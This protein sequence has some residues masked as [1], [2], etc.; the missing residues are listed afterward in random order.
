MHVSTFNRPY[1]TTPALHISLLFVCLLAGQSVSAATFYVDGTLGNNSNTGADWGHSFA[2]IVRAEQAAADGD[3]VYVKS[4]TYIEPQTP[5]GATGNMTFSK[6]ISWIADDGN[7]ALGSVIMR[8]MSGSTVMQFAGTKA[9]SWR[10]FTFDG[11][12]T[13][14][15]LALGSTAP[16]SNKTWTDVTFKDA[17]TYQLRFYQ[18]AGTNNVCTRCT[19]TGSGAY[20]VYSDNSPIVLNTPTFSLSNTSSSAVYTPNSPTTS[21]TITGGNITASGSMRLI[22][23]QSPSVTISNFNIVS[24]STNVPIYNA[25]SSAITLTNITGSVA[26]SL[27]YTSGG[28]SSVALSG[29]VLTIGNTLITAASTNTNAW[30]IENNTIT[31][32]GATPGYILSRGFSSLTTTEPIIIR[33]NTFSIDSNLTYG[34]SLVKIDA[35]VTISDNIF[36]LNAGAVNSGDIIALSDVTNPTIVRNTITNLYALNS[37]PIRISAVGSSFTGIADIE[38]NTITSNNTIGY[39][40]GLGSEDAGTGNVNADHYN[41]STI[42]S[43]I[44]HGPVYNGQAT[45]GTTHALFVG[46][47][48]FVD[49]KYNKVSGSGYA[50]VIKG[51]PSDWQYTSGVYQNTFVGNTFYA[52]P[53]FKGA[54]NVNCFN[55]TIIESTTQP[56][57]QGMIVPIY[58]NTSYGGA[59]DSSGIHFF[60]NLIIAGSANKLI[61]VDAF[62]TANSVFRNNVYWNADS[63]T[64]SQIFN[65]GGV[66]ISSFANWVTASSDTDSH[67]TDPQLTSTSNLTPQMMSPAVDAGTVIPSGFTI[68]SDIDNNPFYGAPDIGAYEFQPT[69]IVGTHPFES[70]RDI[71]IYDNAHYRYLE[72]NTNASTTL[73]TVTPSSG[74]H[75][76]TSNTSHET[77]ADIKISQWTP[78][79]EGVKAW[80]IQTSSSLVFLLEG[81]SPTSPYLAT[82][83]GNRSETLSTNPSGLLTLDFTPSSTSAHTLSI[84]LLP[85]GNGP[86]ANTS[87]QVNGASTTQHQQLI[88]PQTSETHPPATANTNKGTTMQQSVRPIRKRLSIPLYIGMQNTQIKILQELL[89]LDKTTTVATSGAGSINN[90]TEYFGEKTRDAVRRL[91]IKY[92]LSQPN[93]PAFGMVGPK[94]RMQLNALAE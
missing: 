43:N 68:A 2:Q 38:H 12:G 81:L 78:T 86:I 27:V 9:T 90:E 44:I 4:G 77:Y 89:N 30:N 74:S 17:S 83:D 54:K 33:N 37:S 14:T 42:A 3:T 66:D 16:Q 18:S 26:G 59:S 63:S 31:F 56:S 46:H 75:W 79:I 11:E 36:T 65:W 60:N 53:Y 34:I 88:A 40:I 47:Q 80:S 23:A 39:M 94:T 49:V 29:S 51:S 1:R 52:G 70:M 5:G 92:K 20:G 58:K 72:P 8:R 82:T 76:S 55:N 57:A 35:P 71:R 22:N 93:D 24:T 28:N 48:R 73:L 84:S 25:A 21:I 91:Q 64:T 15:Y 13:A 50:A 10:G 69:L 87:I 62:S 19:F 7:G 61:A 67:F 45:G 41:G 85:L 32:T 6:E